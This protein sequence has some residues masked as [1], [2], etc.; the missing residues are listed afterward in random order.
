M[1]CRF[2]KEYANYKIGIL[3]DM[4]KDFPEKAFALTA[5]TVLIRQCVKKWEQGMVTTDEAMAYI[6][7]I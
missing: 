3:E 7:D 5:Q 6:A 4:E 1:S 2:V